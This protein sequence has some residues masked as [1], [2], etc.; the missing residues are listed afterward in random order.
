MEGD[1]ILTQEEA[2]TIHRDGYLRSFLVMWVVTWN[3]SDYPRQ[4][5]VRPRYIA[6]GADHGL[7]AVLL[8]DSLDAVREQL[9][10]G[11]TKMDRSPNDDPR[12]VEIWV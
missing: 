11:L 6:A 10:L 2:E 9:P 12:I 5:A 7:Q 1:M 3:P 8:A 4:A